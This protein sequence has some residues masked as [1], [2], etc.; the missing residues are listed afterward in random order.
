[1]DATSKAVDALQQHC[2]LAVLL[3]LFG[4]RRL[5]SN[6]SATWQSSTL[7]LKR[8]RWDLDRFRPG[9]LFDDGRRRLVVVLV[10]PSF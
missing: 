6:L 4:V 9:N 8:L 5:S 10:S 7:S 2:A 1:M 3:I